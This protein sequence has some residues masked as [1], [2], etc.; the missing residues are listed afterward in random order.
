M[1]IRKFA[2]PALKHHS[3]MTLHTHTSSTGDLF[4]NELSLQLILQSSLCFMDSHECHNE[5]TKYTI[6]VK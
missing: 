5:V 3:Q 6:N 2:F 1:E 4:Q